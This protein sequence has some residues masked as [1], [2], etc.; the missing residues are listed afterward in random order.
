M[1][2]RINKDE[3]DKKEIK[4]DIITRKKGKYMNYNIKE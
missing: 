1:E 2:C 3:V 4:R